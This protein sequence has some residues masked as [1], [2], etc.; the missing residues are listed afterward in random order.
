V[1]VLGG[2][3]GTNR[4]TFELIHQA[5]KYGARVALFG[6]K[7]NLAESQLDI[8]DFMRLVADGEILPLEA[9]KAYH[10]ALQK[11]KIAPVRSLED[12][13]K[14]TEAVLKEGASA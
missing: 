14:L 3:A 6:R 12:D 1:G 13:G 4:D 2:G 7:I 5:E 8:V 10:G 11:K 9:V